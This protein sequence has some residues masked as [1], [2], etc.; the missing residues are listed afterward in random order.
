[1]DQSNKLKNENQEL[2]DYVTDYAKEY[3]DNIDELLIVNDKNDEDE[4]NGKE[5]G[6]DKENQQDLII[7]FSPADN[8]ARFDSS[9]CLNC[10]TEYIYH[11]V[12]GYHDAVEKG[13]AGQITLRNFHEATGEF[14]FK[15]DD[16]IADTFVGWFGNGGGYIVLFLKR[17]GT[18]DY[19]APYGNDFQ[20][21]NLD[22]LKDIDYFLQVG[23]TAKGSIYGGGGTVLA[24]RSDGYFYDLSEYDL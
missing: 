3:N 18:V 1:M 16:A 14:D 15:F 22:E 11:Y 17:N 20:V 19:I 6:N 9:K 23:S 2:V 10:S 13:I 5:V 24:F 12:S 7:N 8:T 21:K 4:S